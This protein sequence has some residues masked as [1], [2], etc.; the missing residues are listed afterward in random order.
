MA[1]LAFFAAVVLA[2]LGAWILGRC[3]C[4]S[5]ALGG[6]DLGNFGQFAFVEYDSDIRRVVFADYPTGEY[7]FYSRVSMWWIGGSCLLFSVALYGVCWVAKR[8]S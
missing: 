4:V 5:I 2:V 7:P 8:R 6:W 3:V 1:R